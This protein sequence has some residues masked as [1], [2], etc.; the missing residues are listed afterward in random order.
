M[1]IWY[2]L[3]LFGVSAPIISSTFFP[4]ENATSRFLNTFAIGFI[5]RPLGA[6]IFGYMGDKYGRRR[7]LLT[8][9]TLASVSSTAIGII[10]DFR[11]IGI[12][13]PILLLSCRII[14]GMAAGGETSINST[15]LIEHSSTKKNIGFLGS[16]KAFSG[17]L[18]SIVCFILIY[19]C[20]KF[21]GENYEIWGWRLLFYFCFVMGVIGFLTRYIMS[22]S[23]AYKIHSKHNNY[24][25]WELIKHY[26]R[27]F[28]ISVGAG[29]AQNA[30]VYSAIMFYNV[31]IAELIFS[32]IDIK[33]TVRL[34]AD[35]L[36]GISA[37]L[38]AALSDKYG[39][40]NIMV[41][42][43]ITLA[44]ASLAML[45]LLSSSN[46]N[47]IILTYLLLTIPI[48]ASFGIY[49]SLTCELFPTKV[50]C[51]GFS[52]ANNISAGIFGGISPSI[53]RLLVEKTG[54]N[55]VAGI[56]L[57][58]CVLMSLISVLYIRVQ[59]KKVDW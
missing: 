4:L 34:L 43:L 42:I 30:I 17:A 15:F 16:M 14:Q 32:G 47:T 52:L 31:S 19:I 13:S 46:S 57:V 50:R 6:F 33:N 23:L 1:I 26:K 55:L 35:I 25:F 59:D 36:F 45:S 22:E 56:Y 53:C 39:R 7:V 21:T 58:I 29:I 5:F 18:G 38:F 10:P 12:L 9:V 28:A 54:N 49:N 3:T 27:P 41:I 40:K 2:E 51:I 44:C 48:A 11:T 37:V 8:S 20:K 24:P